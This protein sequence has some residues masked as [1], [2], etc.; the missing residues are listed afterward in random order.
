MHVRKRFRVDLDRLAY[1][2]GTVGPAVRDADRHV[3]KC[4][5]GREALNKTLDVHLFGPFVRSTDDLLVVHREVLS[6]RSAKPLVISL[7]CGSLMIRSFSCWLLRAEPPLDVQESGH[8]ILLGFL[9][10]GPRRRHRFSRFHDRWGKGGEA[11]HTTG[12]MAISS[13]AGFVSLEASTGECTA[14]NS[15]PQ[16]PAPGTHSVSGLRRCR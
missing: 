5:I 9:R 1:S 16:C 12:G 4:S 15:P 13:L 6:V 8:C 10:V 2:G 3:G 7:V 14:S 11:S